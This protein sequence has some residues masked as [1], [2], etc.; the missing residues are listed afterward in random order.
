[1][2]RFNWE[3]STDLLLEESQVCDWCTGLIRQQ[4][5]G[6]TPLQLITT[7][8]ASK[9]LEFSFNYFSLKDYKDLLRMQVKFD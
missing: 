5:A 7:A 1:M 6:E 9:H 4:R 8:R 2:Q 3:V